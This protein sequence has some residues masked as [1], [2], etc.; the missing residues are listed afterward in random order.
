M[1]DNTLRSLFLLSD[2]LLPA[3]RDSGVIDRMRACKQVKKKKRKPKHVRA[4]RKAKKKARRKS[5]ISM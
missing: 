5:R 2:L 4:L 1:D 3:T